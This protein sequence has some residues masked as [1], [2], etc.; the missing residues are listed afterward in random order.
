MASR[1]GS[2]CSLQLYPLILLSHASAFAQVNPAPDEDPAPTPADHSA[3]TPEEGLDEGDPWAGD[4]APP[5]EKPTD[6]EGVAVAPVLTQEAQSEPPGPVPIHVPTE[7][8]GA[9]EGQATDVGDATPKTPPSPY[10][11][12]LLLEGSAK[13]GLFATVIGAGSFEDD[14]VET[15]NETAGQFAGQAMLGIIPGGG[16]FMMGGRLRGGAYVNSNGAQALIGADLLFGA[17]FA[18]RDGR[19]FAYAM[20]GMGVEL[21]PTENIDMLTLQGIGG[22]VSGGLNFGGGI[23]VGAN[24]DT[25]VI[26]FGM[27]MG[28]GRLF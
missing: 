10:R 21:I 23:E 25:A 8:Q 7:M 26:M 2:L 28:W 1:L 15:K 27:H 5:A 18:R 19:N 3:E 4:T 12:I 17:N 11:S 16:T 20:G 22:V 24:E 14:E 9:E 13:Y 6:Q